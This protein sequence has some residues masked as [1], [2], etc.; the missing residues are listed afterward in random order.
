MFG[1]CVRLDLFIEFS[2]QDGTKIFTGSADKTAK[3]WDLGSN[4]HIQ[5][6]QVMERMNNF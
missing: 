3:M 5:V 6:A 2:A 1:G 4:Q